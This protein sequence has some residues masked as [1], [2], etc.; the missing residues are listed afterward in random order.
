M[1]TRDAVIVAAA[2]TPVGKA[3][4]GSLATTRPDEMAAVVIQDLLRRAEGLEASQVEDVIMGCAFPEAEQGLNVA[5]LS[6]LRAGLPNTV[7]GET[8]NRFCSSGLQS[9]A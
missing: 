9:I 8:I 5:R 2:R 6:A 3:K 1:N 7:P 4:R